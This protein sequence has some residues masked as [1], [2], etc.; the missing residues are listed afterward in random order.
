MCNKAANRKDVSKITEAFITPWTFVKSPCYLFI[1]VFLNLEPDF[2]FPK[3]IKM[4]PHISLSSDA[5][6]S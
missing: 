1:L 6:F 4:R 3:F 5:S 2:L